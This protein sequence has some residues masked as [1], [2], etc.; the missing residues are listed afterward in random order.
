MDARD[1]RS[2]RWLMIAGLLLAACSHAWLQARNLLAPLPAAGERLQVQ[3]R[4]LSVPALAQAGWRFDARV[5]FPRHPEWR[6]RRLRVFLPPASPAPSTG[7]LWQYAARLEAPRDARERRGALRDH[8][9]GTARVS[10]GPLTR[11]LEAAGPGLDVLRERLARRIADRVADP[12]AAA[13]LAA[14][15][16]GVTGEVSVRQW[17]V[18]N[19]TGITH[20]VAISGMHVT[21]FALFSMAAARRLWGRVGM[22]GLPRRELF[23]AA[24][25]IALALLYA[26][27]AGF[28][29][30]ARRTVVMLAAF[31]VARECARRTRTGWSLAVALFVVLLLDPW[32]VLGAGFWLSFLAVAALVLL[33]GA[34]F[35]QGAPLAAAARL[36]WQ[37]SIALLPAT[38]AIFGSFS[39]VGLAANALAIPVFTVLLVPPVLLA[40]AC[41]LLPVALA[42][43]CGDGL[44]DLAGA[45]A[46]LLWPALAWCADLPAALWR[47][48]APWSWYLLAMPFTLVVLLPWPLRLRLPALL[49]L[50][51]PFLLREPRPRPGELWIDVQ[52]RGA[53]GVTLL[54]THRH[55]LLWGTGETWGSD[56]RRF[57]RQ[58]AP[59][60]RA[61]GYR[62]IDLW[63]P[64]RLG[65]DAQAA[66]RVAAGEFQIRALR[67]PPARAVPPEALACASEQWSWDG[68]AFDLQVTPEGRGCVLVARR[69]GHAFV[70]GG[71]DA[72]AT[73]AMREHMSSLRLDAAG[74]ALRGRRLGL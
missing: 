24:I 10:D 41:Y 64:G 7:E 8:L 74:L 14:L 12:S 56:G 15:A 18:F 22:P 5:S 35:A 50:C 51:S 57:E 27:L 33:A 31:L 48:Q 21:F 13:L 60:L 19:A 11:R 28:S 52:G 69:E 43:W 1:A 9:S 30:P 36:Q 66:L 4:V 71:A 42:A 58:V 46:A 47:T 53:T 37:V 68:I 54:R 45:V 6:A 32:A 70:L 67:L 29:V 62:Y 72:A 49:L 61:A 2:F 25:G 38:V 59:R 73:D 23:A 20:L 65:P 63:L 44:V 40:T 3:A 34:R 39:A 17:Q 16:V 26:L 55:L